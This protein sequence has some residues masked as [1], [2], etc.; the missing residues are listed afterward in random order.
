MKLFPI[1]LFVLVAHSVQAGNT[2]I[3]FS[4]YDRSLK[5]TGVNAYGAHVFEG[6]IKIQGNL[7]LRV[8]FGDD[9]EP[10]DV[11]A[12]FF[13]NEESLNRLPNVISGEMRGYAN[14]ISLEPA[15]NALDVA[16]E[17][18]ENLKQNGESGVIFEIPVSLD[19]YELLTG[20]QCDQ[21]AYWTTKFT[22]M[23]LKQPIF[24]IAMDQNGC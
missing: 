12:S 15:E 6:L 21:R 20:G 24:K 23:K 2:D 8:F 9:G 4:D 7:R 14:I 11:Y 18:I 1:V 10:G 22:L 5:L 17:E 13:P 3:A 16:H 19:L